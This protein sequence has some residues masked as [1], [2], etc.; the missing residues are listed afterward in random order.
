MCK[1]L[2]YRV[3]DRKVAD[4]IFQETTVDKTKTELSAIGF[5]GLAKYYPDMERMILAMPEEMFPLN[6]I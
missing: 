2:K 1:K 4:K 5:H 6:D 3:P